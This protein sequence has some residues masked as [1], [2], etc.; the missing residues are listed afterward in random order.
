[1]S[2][3]KAC[4]LGSEEKKAKTFFLIGSDYIWPRTSNKIARKHIENVLHGSGRG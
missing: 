1:M 3:R 4:Q 2:P